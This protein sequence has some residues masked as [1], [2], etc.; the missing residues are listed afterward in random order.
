MT[1]AIV[2][3]QTTPLSV[4]M[5]PSA[6]SRVLKY[7]TAYGVESWDSSLLA[8]LAHFDMAA[9]DHPGQSGG[10]ADPGPVRAMY[11]HSQ[12]KL[13][14][15]IDT[16]VD[17]QGQGFTNFN[18]SSSSYWGYQV[19]KLY[20]AYQAA[21]GNAFDGVFLDNCYDQSCGDYP[22]CKSGNGGAPYAGYADYR[23][24]GKWL[25]GQLSHARQIPI[26]LEN[27][28]D[29]VLASCADLWM[30]EGFPSN[31]VSKVADLAAQTAAGHGAVALAWGYPDT[32]A[33]CLWALACFLCGATDGTAYFAFSSIWNASM[34]YYPMM[35]TDYGTPLGPYT[36]NGNTLTRQF[37]KCTVTC[38]P[39]ITG[40][41][42]IVMK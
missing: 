25:T 4:A 33:N 26:V 40:S 18:T 6:V 38:D 9:I 14:A 17:L 34:G 8:A 13:L 20:A 3:G 42:S 36:Q 27:A 19:E 12:L 41:A 29:A 22:L 39:T 30:L 23:T 5:T 35:D 11:S 2:S 37:T 7:L 31:K 28:G 21:T 24:L 32:K 10:G 1:V 16:A 15:Y